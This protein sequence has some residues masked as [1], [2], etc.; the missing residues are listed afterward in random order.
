M[1]GSEVVSIFKM[2]LVQ[3]LM[4]ND[5]DRKFQYKTLTIAKLIFCDI[6]DFFMTIISKET[7]PLVSLLDKRMSIL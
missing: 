5:F 7:L 2:K 3:E 1:Q 4:R 6:Q